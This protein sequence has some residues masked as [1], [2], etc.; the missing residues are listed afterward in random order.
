MSTYLITGATGVVGSEICQTLLVREEARLRLLIRADSDVEVQRR[1]SSL[2]D[3]WGLGD[4]RA[5]GKVVALRGDVAKPQLGLAASEYARLAT[6]CTHI[7]HSAAAVRMN[8]AIDEARRSA[9]GSVENILE[10]AQAARR[11]GQFV[12]AEFLSTVGVGG[13]LEGVLPE[14]WITETRTFHNTYEQAKAEAEAVIA[15]ALG[16]G[17]TGTVHR[18]SMVVGNSRTG[19]IRQF[20]IFYQLVELLSGRMT[21]GLLPPL[22]E[23]RLDVV[24]VDYVATAVAWSSSTISTAGRVLHLCSGPDQSLPVEE[25]RRVVRERF[26]VAGI[27]LPKAIRV[28]IGALK[29][30]TRTLAPVLPAG[31]RRTLRTLP[32]FLDYLAES[33]SFANVETAA[34]LEAAEIRL[35]RTR[36]FLVRVLDSYLARDVLRS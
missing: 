5:E 9:V 27:A 7:V 32:I 8:L 21:F 19:R 2:I 6:E 12:K 25:L 11:N 31:T 1:L 29:A 4:V 3:Y 24:P 23:R 34:L 26:G 30:A 33:Q 17:L 15:S 20:Q 36:D 35:P 10:L 18:P 16:G 22:R 28:P 14:R 13:R